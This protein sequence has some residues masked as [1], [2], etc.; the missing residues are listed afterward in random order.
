MNNNDTSMN[1]AGFIF[2]FGFVAA[3]VGVTSFIYLK[4]QGSGSSTGAILAS[5]PP[6]TIPS[7]YGYY[8]CTE[9]M[10]GAGLLI[11]RIDNKG[12]SFIE[13][14]KAFDDPST[15]KLDDTKFTITGTTQA[16]GMVRMLGTSESVQTIVWKTTDNSTPP[17]VKKTVSKSQFTLE[18]EQSK[19]AKPDSVLLTLL[20]E[21][22]NSRT[23][24]FE[25]KL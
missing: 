1:R 11:L 23:V 17:D 4:Q 5:T 19:D 9:T 14:T 12:I 16:N 2:A 21:G 20:D 8:R 22:G 10:E 6:S 25:R 15:G 3:I 18:W 7:Y 24:H 13:L